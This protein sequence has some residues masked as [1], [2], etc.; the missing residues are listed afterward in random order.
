[1]K[2]IILITVWQLKTMGVVEIT[3]VEAVVHTENFEN[4]EYLHWLSLQLLLKMLKILNRISLHLLGLHLQV[5][6]ILRLLLYLMYHYVKCFFPV[7]PMNLKMKLR[8]LR[9]TF[10][11]HSLRSV[12][13][14]LNGDKTVSMNT[15]I[16]IIM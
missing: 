14:K 6:Y 9:K 13:E 11:L 2:K 10:M 15:S 1:M 5:P 3:L 4:S 16:D 7:L 12:K 8:W